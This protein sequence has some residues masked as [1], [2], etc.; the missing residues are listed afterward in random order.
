[1]KWWINYRNK[2]IY[3]LLKCNCATTVYTAL[4]I[5][6]FGKDQQ[7]WVDVVENDKKANSEVLK[8]MGI[9]FPIG[10]L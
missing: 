1:M 5:G 6:G 8:E 7:K 9:D 3:S 4:S 10:I 2:K